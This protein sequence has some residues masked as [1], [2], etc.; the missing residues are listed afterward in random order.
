MTNEPTKRKNKPGQG[1]KPKGSVSRVKKS[2][3]ID[4][5]TLTTLEAE[6]KSQGKSLSDVINN[7]LNV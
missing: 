1:R 5:T 2:I 4:A 7:R 3:L 6:A